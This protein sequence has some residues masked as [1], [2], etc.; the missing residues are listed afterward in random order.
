MLIKVI[1]IKGKV[2]KSLQTKNLK[3]SPKREEIMRI[4]QKINN[5]S[6]LMMRA[7]TKALISTLL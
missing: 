6:K 5:L 4:L 7:K 3:K 2:K 1:P